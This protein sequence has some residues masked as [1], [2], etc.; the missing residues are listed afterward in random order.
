MKLSILR[1]RWIL[2]KM[3]RVVTP[4]IVIKTAPALNS[5]TSVKYKK[6]DPRSQR[7]KQTLNIPQLDFATMK[8]DVTQRR[9]T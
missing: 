9:M 7:E 6:E 5:S 1:I 2:H 3:E 4:I 8:S